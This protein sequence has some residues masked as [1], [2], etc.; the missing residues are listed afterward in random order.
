M[1]GSTGFVGAEVSQ[2]L[3]SNN[4]KVWRLD[5]SISIESDNHFC[6]D[7]ASKQDLNKISNLY[8]DA[9][10]HCAAQTDVRKSV[11]DP[12]ADLFTNGL[13]TLNLVEFAAANAVKNVVYINSGG[14]I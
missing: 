3:E 2:K 11:E 9:I 10:V 4:F 13:G 14:A 6:V 1:T 7:I 8:L 5:K 12:T